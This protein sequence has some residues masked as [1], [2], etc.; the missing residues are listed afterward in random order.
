M[1]GLVGG[2][3]SSA[4]AGAISAKN[5]IENNNLK[6]TESLEF[7][8]KMIACKAAGGDCFDVV[9]EYIGKSKKNSSELSGKCSSGGVVCVSYEE[10]LKAATNVALDEDSQQFRMGD[11]LKDQDVITLVKYLNGKDIR[12]VEFKYFYS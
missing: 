1:G 2:D 7:D 8:K 6:E 11:K 12:N 5:A 10:V 9:M 3:S 4:V